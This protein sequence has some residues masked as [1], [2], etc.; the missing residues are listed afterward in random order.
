MNYLVRNDD[1]RPAMGMG[2]GEKAWWVSA[3]WEILKDKARRAG[4][5]TPAELADAA[6]ASWLSEIGVASA[7]TGE[8]ATPVK[9]PTKSSG[10]RRGDWAG[11]DP[12]SRLFTDPLTMEMVMDTRSAHPAYNHVLRNPLSVGMLKPTGAL[13]TSRFWL[14]CRTL[15]QVRLRK[16]R[17]RRCSRPILLVIQRSAWRGC[18]RGGE[19]CERYPK[20]SLRG[21]SGGRPPLE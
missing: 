3:R 7:T 19:L 11:E 1:A 6:Y 10:H 14:A 9:S 4:A 16:L 18:Y 5:T 15:L 2:P 21:V 13:L 12:V 8:P 17:C 20:Y